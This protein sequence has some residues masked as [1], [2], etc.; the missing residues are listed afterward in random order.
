[1]HIFEEGQYPFGDEIV[2]AEQIRRG[3]E[4]AQ[5]RNCAMDVL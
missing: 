4:F 3:Y 1:M 2:D 5:W